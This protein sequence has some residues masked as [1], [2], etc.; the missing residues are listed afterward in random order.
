MN[1]LENS[2]I[3]DIQRQATKTLDKEN[4]LKQN[5]QN[6]DEY[7]RNNITI[8]EK[9]KNIAYKKE[10]NDIEAQEA[11][12]KYINELGKH[13]VNLFFGNISLFKAK[14]KVYFIYVWIAVYAGLYV[15]RSCFEFDIFKLI[16]EIGLFLIIFILG[17]FLK[18]NIANIILAFTQNKKS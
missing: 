7:K 4:L 8:K 18:D 13:F 17:K 2:S 3:E 9:I 14:F 5:H 15:F 1:D 12:S 11:N 10:L 16:N 6:Y